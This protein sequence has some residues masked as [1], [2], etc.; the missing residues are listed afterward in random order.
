[1]KPI[2][3]TCHLLC[4]LCVTFAAAHFAAAEEAKA[5]ASSTQTVKTPPEPIDPDKAQQL[6]TDKKV[7]VLDVRTPAEFAS[8]HIAGATNIDYHNQDFKKKLEQLPK[9]KSYLVNCA[10]GG[11][12]AKACK[13]MNQLDF[14]SVY[15]LKGGMSAWEKAGKPIEK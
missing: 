4:I 12:S 6:V 1:M 9:D 5:P 3:K 2:K 10:V 7:V 8:G 15:D 11:R 14:K 13:M